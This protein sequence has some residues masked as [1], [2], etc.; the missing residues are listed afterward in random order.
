[1]EH[2]EN[3]GEADETAGDGDVGG[4][5]DIIDSDEILPLTAISENKFFDLAP[6]KLH[7]L[8]DFQLEDSGEMTS[9]PGKPFPNADKIPIIVSVGQID[10]QHVCD[11]THEEKMSVDTVVSALIDQNGDLKGLSKRGG[12]GVSLSLISSVTPL[13]KTTGREVFN[14]VIKGTQR[15]GELAD[16]TKRFSWHENLRNL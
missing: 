13:M 4:I 14:A 15:A 12:S 5:G 7:K 16:T 2:G 9:T 6:L 11:M 1:M 8:I 10:G 3:G